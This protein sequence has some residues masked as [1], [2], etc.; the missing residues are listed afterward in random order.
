MRLT[1][2][3]EERDP[4]NEGICDY[5]AGNEEVCTNGDSPLCADFVAPDKECVVCKYFQKPEEPEFIN[6]RCNN[7]ELRSDEN[8]IIEIVRWRGDTCTTMCYWLKSEHGPF[9]KFVGDRPQRYLGEYPH[10]GEDFINFLMI[11]QVEAER[12]A[13]AGK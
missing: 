12:R 10:D 5:Y 3:F 9:V 13:K 1:F 7:M 8:K 4:G 11:G 6:I 2:R